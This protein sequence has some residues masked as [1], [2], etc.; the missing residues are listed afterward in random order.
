VALQ[1]PADQ[2]GLIVVVTHYPPGAPKW[3]P[4]EHRMSGVTSANWAG[5]PLAGYETTLKYARA[6][7][8]ESGF[9]CRACLGRK[10]YPARQ[11]GAAEDK[12]RVRLKPSP[13][14]P[15]WDYTIRPH[16]SHAKC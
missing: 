13:V 9:R 16:R 6:A 11:R 1:G 8:T 14:P 7:R 2:T 4:V 15:K 10:D 3:N 5:E 12:A